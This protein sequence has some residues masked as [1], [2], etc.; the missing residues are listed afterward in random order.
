MYVKDRGVQRHIQ[1]SLRL[2][3][4]VAFSEVGLDYTVTRNGAKQDQRWV[5]REMLELAPAGMPVV[6]NCRAVRPGETYAAHD[7]RRIAWSCLP[8]NQP[9]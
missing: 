6:H 7:L 9:L 5:L 4:V 3:G 2:L 8:P 1:T